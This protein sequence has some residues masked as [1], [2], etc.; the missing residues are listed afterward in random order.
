M[1]IVDVNEFYSPTGGGVRTY[2]DRKMGI[3]ADM[4]HELI[5]IAPALQNSIEERPGGGKIYWV[6][7]PPLVLDRNYGIF[8]LDE[9]IWNLLDE[10]K[11]DI[12][13]CSSPWRPAW[14][15]AK[16]QGDAVKVF[17]AHG[18]QIG[19]YPQRWLDSVA[20]PIQVEQ[21]FAWYTRY[22]NDFLKYYD[23]L[24]TNGPALA[25][26]FRRRGMHVDASMPLGIERNWFSPDLRDEKLRVAL[27][28]QL[29]LP[30][31]GHLLLGLGRHHK[32]KRWPLVID[33]VEAAAN[34]LPVGLMLIGDGP[35]RGALEQRIA[36]SP[37]IKIFRPVYDRVRFSRIMASCDALIHGSDAEPF[38]LVASEAL[39][40]GLP[41]IGPDEGGFAEIAEPLF[42]E[43]YRARDTYSAAD[44]IRRMFARE[45][46]LLRNA[47]RNA[48][49]R[50]R[51]DADH[52]AELM[53][54]YEGLLEA[55]RGGA[56]RAAGNS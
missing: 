11:P 27:L 32:E 13:E 35:Q 51:S 39:A 44:A 37:H 17:F 31:E 15:V 42:A 21:A 12:V 53:A 41:L 49:A 30:P 10:L 43:T 6:K 26:R 52:A 3:M 56:L 5:V 14:T 18:D 54:Y 25:K 4:G 16:W 28:A 29:G 50:V 55:K 24:V 34:D 23:A 40:S 7:A 46:T 48:A 2:L 8:V 20:T 22:M 38:G 36:G 47:A 9:P 33:A 1:R 45:P 19:A